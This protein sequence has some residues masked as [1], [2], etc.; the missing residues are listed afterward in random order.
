MLEVISA[1]I[2]GRAASQKTKNLH[3][4][5]RFF[6]A[7]SI[8]NDLKDPKDESRID[9]IKVIAGVASADVK[10]ENTSENKPPQ[11]TGQETRSEETS[12]GSSN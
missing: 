3:R 9:L 6:L 8:C 10:P 4:H 5:Q 1:I 12:N 2:F 11:Q 7:N